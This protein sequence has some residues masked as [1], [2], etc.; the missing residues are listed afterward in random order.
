[1][2]SKRFWA[3]G[4]GVTV[5]V[6][7]GLM[8]GLTATGEAAKQRPKRAVFMSAVEW[9]GT[10]SVANEAYPGVRSLPCNGRGCGYESFAPGDEEL[11][12]DQTKWAIET[13]RFDTSTVVAYA[14]ERLTLNIFGVNARFHDIVIPAFKK[15]FRVN[16]GVLSKVTIDVDRPGIYK[17]LCITHPPAH[18]ADLVVLPKP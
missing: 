10:A 5:V 6:A 7:A 2:G 4:A 16:R 17:I 1:M 18:Q 15:Q 14:G 11:D 8:L 12:G 13:Y 9:K 3:I